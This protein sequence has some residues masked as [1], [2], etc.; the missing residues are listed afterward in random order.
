MK[1]SSSN[2]TKNLKSVFTKICEENNIEHLIEDSPWKK[3]K[4]D[5]DLEKNVL[6]RESHGSFEELQK[7][8]DKFVDAYNSRPQKGLGGMSPKKKALEYKKRVK[9]HIPP[10]GTCKSM[11]PK[12]SF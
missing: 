5:K 2:S 6:K 7:R 12:G 11:P 9:L 3:E 4:I 10:K 1:D 8:L